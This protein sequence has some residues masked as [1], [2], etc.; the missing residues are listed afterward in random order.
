MKNKIVAYGE[1]M[2]RLTPQNYGKIEDSNNYESYYGGTE[3]NVLI[4]LSHLGDSTEYITKVP[5]NS[6]GEGVIRHLLRHKV[7]TENIVKDGTTLGIYFMEQ[8]FGNRASK[9][10]YSRKNAVVNTLTL[11]EL[12]L[13]KIFDNASW[14]HVSGISLAISK[15]S[16]NISIF[17]AKEAK[18]RNLKVSFDFNYRATLWSIE[19]ANKAYKEI[20]PYV[21][22]CF[23]NTFDLENLLDIKEAKDE[24]T[25]KTFLITYNVAYLANTTRNVTSSTFNSLSASLYQMENDNLKVVKTEEE[26]FEILDRIGGGDA[27]VGG[28]IHVLNADFSNVKDAIDL[29]L[30]CGILKHLIK[31]DVLSMNQDEI[32]AWINNHSKDVHR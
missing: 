14:F 21:D 12:E 17:L 19:E 24:D 11:D 28:V 2:M 1:I 15:N 20:M 3:S 30:K 9:V 29:G 22:V 10:I 8:G 32:Y 25:I 6:L 16:K 4:A 7:N 13:D 23:G 5:N 26:E 27:F 31:G 18:K